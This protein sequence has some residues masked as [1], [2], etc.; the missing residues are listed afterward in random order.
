L[1][2]ADLS[3]L[4]IAMESYDFVVIGGGSAGYSAVATAAH[5]GL[6]SVCIEG[7]EE[8]GGL[9]ILRGCMPSKT[10]I[11]S[12]N[13][14]LT[15]RRAEEFGL[16]AGHLAF[17]AAAIIRRKRKLIGGFAEYRAQQL[18]S[19]LFR[20]ARG[21]AAF[22][23][24]FH[25]KVSLRDGRQETIE[26]KTFLIST[27]SVLNTVEVPGL[28]KVGFL[29]SDLALDTERWPRSIIILGG[30]AVALEFAH[31]Y[32]AFGSIVTILQRSGQIIKEADRDI[33][34]A[35][36]EAFQNR[37][38]KII[39]GTKLKAA[40][41]SESGKLI[42]YEKDGVEH[43]LEADEIFFALGRKPAVE[44]VGLREAGVSVGRGG[45][46]TVNST[47]QTA[48]P[49]IFASGDVTGLHEIVHIAIQQGEIAARNAKNLLDGKALEAIDYRLKLFAMFSEPQLAVV[50]LTEREA[51][52]Q[53]IAVR[54][55]RYPFH[56]HGKSMVRGDVEGFVKLVVDARSGEILGGA[57][58]GPEASELIHEIVVAMH[59]HATADVLSKIPHYH[60]TL[61]EIWTYPAEELGRGFRRAEAKEQ[62]HR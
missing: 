19:G 30:G 34:N 27:G 33:A 3:Y 51:E 55:A 47:M 15:L 52:Q 10:F 17:D 46:V 38:I 57:V 21:C 58:V 45:A 24:P 2:H 7:A 5:L 14:F 39:C 43:V 12:A 16:S 44:G 31:F 50:G 40:E 60:P 9:C 18:N 36:A 48:Q 22:A 62:T 1:Q 35:L 41:L 8:L 6:K 26:G 29:H 54:V 61:S 59:F 42:R 32:N 28:D 25:V 11:E 23:D 4:P 56:D 49:H 20:L 13:R 37:G 53:G